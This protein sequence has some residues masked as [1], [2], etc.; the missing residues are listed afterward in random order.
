MKVVIV[1]YY[2]RKQHIAKNRDTN[3]KLIERG[4]G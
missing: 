4:A 3:E 2:Y 1:Y